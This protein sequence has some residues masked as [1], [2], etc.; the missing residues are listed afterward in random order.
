MAIFWTF[1]EGLILLFLW[2]SYVELSDSLVVNKKRVIFFSVILF[3]F[4]AGILFLAEPLLGQ[5]I[6]FENRYH[7]SV[8]RKVLWN[9]FCTVWVIL[10]GIIAVYVFQIYTFLQS[11]SKDRRDYKK[12]DLLCFRIKVIIVITLFL[13]FAFYEGYHVYVS[14]HY[15]LSRSELKNIFVFYIRIC[16]VFW[17]GFEW[18]VAFL[19]IKTYRMLKKL[20]NRAGLT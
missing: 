18:Y 2:Y 10:E 15:H 19:G 5:Y 6:D 20:K 11:V 14:Y 3:L 8:F 13:L 9:F 12:Y 1:V 17:I 16:G 7:R 4:L